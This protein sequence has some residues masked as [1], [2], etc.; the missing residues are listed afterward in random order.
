MW[1]AKHRKDVR[2]VDVR[3]PDEYDGPLGH[4]G[5]AELIPLDGLESHAKRW[6]RDAPL[7]LIC[8]SGRR[9][10]TAALQ[11]MGMGF[12][13]VASVCHGM[14]GLQKPNYSI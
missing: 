6:A 9:S 3:E 7:C 4:L 10:A 11:L 12:T 13:K 2:L 5:D 14:H 8:R 1:V